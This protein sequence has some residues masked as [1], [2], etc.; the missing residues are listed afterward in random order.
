LSR[1]KRLDQLVLLRDFK[2]DKE[3]NAAL[4]A[5][6]KEEFTWERMMSEMTAQLYP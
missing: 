2:D 4:D 6:L 1:L 3:M 5:D